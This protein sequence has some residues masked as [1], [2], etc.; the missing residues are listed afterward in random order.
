M[1]YTNIKQSDKLVEMGLDI[2]TADLIWARSDK[3]CDFQIQIKDTYLTRDSY[4]F[5]NGY[6]KPAWT[7]EALIKQLPLTINVKGADKVTDLE[8][9]LYLHYTKG[10]CWHLAYLNEAFNGNTCYVDNNENL[11]EL[12]VW[13]L[14]W[15]FYN[16]YKESMEKEE[17]K[18]ALGKSWNYIEKSEKVL[19][20]VVRKLA[21]DKGFKNYKEFDCAY[22]G[23]MSVIVS[24]GRLGDGAELT[25]EEMFDLTK[26]QI[27][28]R[29]VNDSYLSEYSKERLIGLLK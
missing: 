10:G 18:K 7:T 2:K 20:N 22:A 3:E 1:E 16:R 14:D 21:K 27:I 19:T 24:V 9:E 4:S 15:L 5:R 8:C 29:L 6:I 28:D 23:D 13:A 12:L 17:L 26:K 25:L 11:V